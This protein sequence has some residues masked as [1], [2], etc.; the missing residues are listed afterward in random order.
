MGEEFRFNM[1]NDEMK[2]EIYQYFFIQA[3]NAFIHK[4]AQFLNDS[5]LIQ[6]H[7]FLTTF[8]AYGPIYGVALDLTPKA[9]LKNAA[10][11]PA[12]LAKAPAEFWDYLIKLMQKIKQKAAGE[13]VEIIYS[14]ERQF[15]F[16]GSEHNLKAFSNNDFVALQHR[17]DQPLVFDL[18]LSIFNLSDDR[19]FTE[20]R[21]ARHWPIFESYVKAK[22]Q[23]GAA[24]RGSLHAI[25]NGHL[26]SGKLGKIDSS[27]NLW[28]FTL[29]SLWSY[30]ATEE[31]FERYPVDPK[32]EQ[33]A[34][35][36]GRNQTLLPIWA[37]AIK[38]Y[39]AFMLQKIDNEEQC[40]IW[41]HVGGRHGDLIYAVLNFKDESYA[42]PRPF[43]YKLV[44][45]TD[46][47][48]P[49][50]GWRPIFKLPIK[51]DIIYSLDAVTADKLRPQIRAKAKARLQEIER[52]LIRDF[53]P[54]TDQENLIKLRPSAAY[55]AK[56]N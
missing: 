22:A 52:D 19:P 24:D 18:P 12:A 9:Q 11:N 46:S 35:V 49:V 42:W 25:Q 48:S 10:Q 8:S 50:D 23:H 17:Y 26:L 37:K 6:A 20:Y 31:Y 40:R 16:I 30:K 43:H 7:V 44:F 34:I 54:L 5:T 28:H 39:V 33:F 53:G 1:S 21:L 2:L 32:Q 13:D 27:E 56:Q 47:F 4:L 29:D 3:H 15:D 38:S 36:H 51:G 41:V 55:A 45:P 14:H